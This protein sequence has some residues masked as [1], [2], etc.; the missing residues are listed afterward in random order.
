MLNA[1]IDQVIRLEVLLQ[2]A[3]L[4][5]I[6][7]FVANP[8]LRMGME[9]QAMGAWM[10]FNDPSILPSVLRDKLRHRV[11]ITLLIALGITFTMIL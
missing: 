3:I 8:D 9:I 2:W 1:F 7:R 11:K 6:V 10:F 4:T 5:I